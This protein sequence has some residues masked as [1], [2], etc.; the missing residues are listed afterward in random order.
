MTAVQTT[1]TTTTTTSSRS[2]SQ[3]IVGSQANTQSVGTYVTDVTIQ[4]YINPTIISFYAY[5]MRPNTLVH[6]FFDS[7]LVDQYCAPGIIPASFTGTGGYEVIAR[8]GDWG[9]PIY[10]DEIG[11]V[12]GQFNVP[13]ASFK[14]GDRKIQ[15]ADVTSLSL[16]TGAITTLSSAMFTASNLSVTRNAVTL[17]TVN[18]TVSYTAISDLVVNTQI[19]Y[20]N[21]VLPDIV[22]IVNNVI[23]NTQII[24]LPNVAFAVPQLYVE[25]APV[26]MPV[27]DNSSIGG[28]DGG[29]GGEPLAQS[30]SI[31]TPGGQ[32]GV[33]VT[34]L[35]LFFQEKSL[36]SN[37][38]V[39]VYLCEVDNGYPNTSCIL[40]FSTTHLAFAN[41]ATSNLANV[42]TNFRFEAPVFLNNN[43]QYAFVVRPDANDPDYTIYTANIGDIDI[44]TGYQ[45]FSQPLLG[46]AF[47][48]AT[49][50][51]WTA[52]QTE[53]IKFNLRRATFNAAQGD[54]YFY[55]S[56]TDYIYISGISYSN[57]TAQ[58]LPGDY[59]YGANGST[60]SWANASKLGTL[61][62]YDNTRNLLYIENSTGAYTGAN[63]VQIHRFANA[64]VMTPNTLTLVAYA[65]TVSVYNPVVDALV[66]QIASI[67][68]SGTSIYF[69]YTGTSNAYSV[70]SLPFNVQPGNHTEFYDKERIVASLSNE[71]AQMS[72]AKSFKLHANLTTTSSWVSPLIDLVRDQQL[73]IANKID[74]V[75]FNYNE[76]LNYSNT[77]SKYVSKVIT[78]AQGQDAEDLSV[79]LTAHRPV[80]TDIT[81]WVKFLNG[82]D[83][84]SIGQKTWTP[85]INQGASIYSDPSN[86]NDFKEMNFVMPSAYSAFTTTGT[87]SA[88]NSS[89]NVYG[90]GT[91]FGSQVQV[92]YWINMAPNTTFTEQSRQVISIV[93]TTLMILNAPFTVTGT[94]Y[95]ANAYYVVVPPTTA[96]KSVNNRIQMTGT[97]TTSTTNNAIIGSGTNFVSQFNPG[98]ILWCANDQQ[99]VVTVTNSTYLTVGAPWTSS[100][101][102]A[103]VYTTTPT[104]VT[105]LNS[106]SALYNT[107]KQFQLK[108]VL[109]SDDSSKVPYL[110]D[111]RVLALQL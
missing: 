59:V 13:A 25:P 111:L 67:A 51:Q 34:S 30:L 57:T 2:G 90:V 44:T 75:G 86:P 6:I 80:G 37:N 97:V 16:G 102:G 22:N 62:F 8:N 68:P 85:L 72:G 60:P 106:N 94:G 54:A 49:Q 40:P 56:N 26:W 11:Q 63:V 27:F 21:T 76:F 109:Q 58:L 78:L 108:I 89:A 96:Y 73:V 110:D 98:T 99:V 103:N 45:V 20:A 55:N 71:T 84:D 69:D 65:N 48:G 3:L 92:G 18:P 82:E 32:A 91:S 70:D 95:T 29:G 35:D 28:G 19:S 74:P 43:K 39:T 88:N 1:T 4:P 100:V 50:A 46:T 36:T 101:A 24:T 93:N 105:Y 77:Q 10:T 9:T 14:T 41:I 42:S 31:I 33:Y 5:N 61:S 83:S 23:T 81:V 52:L 17:T 87:V 104:G 66:P 7:V 47:Y 15:I 79:S 64:S 53:Y 107:F 12:A 38:G